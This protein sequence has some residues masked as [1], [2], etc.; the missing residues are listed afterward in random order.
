MAFVG[1]EG[2]CAPRLGE[3]D[4]AAPASMVLRNDLFTQALCLL[5]AFYDSCN[6]VHADFSEYNILVNH[7]RCVVIDVGQTVEK[8]HPR[9]LDF[10]QR[11]V[12]NIL[13][14]FQSKKLGVRNDAETQ[15]QVLH[16][17]VNGVSFA[18]HQ[19]SEIQR[20]WVANFATECEMWQD[21]EFARA[22]STIVV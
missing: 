19:L 20:E 13:S 15:A 7:K 6:L 21:V 3:M 12:R 17:I 22:L 10:L 5:R 9:A 18:D 4:L 2:K 11:D 14:F 8:N 1:R 16:W